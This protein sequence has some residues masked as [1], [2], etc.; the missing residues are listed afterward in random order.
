VVV[1]I[2]ILAIVIGLTIGLGLQLRTSYGSGVDAKLG[3][4]V[5]R[6]FLAD[7]QA[8]AAALSKAD[9]TLLNSRLTEGALA[10][11]VQQIHA[12]SSTSSLPVVSFEAASITIAKAQDP[13]DPTLL[14]KVEEDGVKHVTI[15]GGPDSEPSEKAIAFHGDFWLR[16]VSGRYL[17]ADQSITTLPTS[18][19]PQLA[20]VATGLLWVGLAGL[21]LR[22]TR[23][24]KALPLPEIQL[25]L[26][27]P[28]GSQRPAEVAEEPTP[29][30]IAIRTFG[31]LRVVEGGKDWAAALNARPVMAF[32]WLRMVVAAVRQGAA[33]VMREEIGR[34]TS[35]GL[36]RETQLRRLRNLL[37]Q[38]LRELPDALRSRI[39]VEPQMLKFA[40]TD[41]SVDAIELLELSAQCAGR[42]MLSPAL[43]VRVRRAVDRSGDPFLP[44]FESVEDLATDHHP[45]C[46]DMIRSVREQLLTKRVELTM[47]LADTYA[48]EHKPADAIAV[49]EP[50][51]KAYPERRDIAQRLAAAYRAAGREDEA[52]GL[53]EVIS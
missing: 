15:P 13:N 33:G 18:Y 34:Q 16:L 23:T 36:D 20:L 30:R 37:Y 44:E 25:E 7:Q 24:P 46:G 17:I 19:L 22:R 26:A 8:E 4:Q 28:P 11:V 35:P 51:L 50:A 3:D 6:D 29:A 38:G 1:S 47:V 9:Q 45:T 21:L 42:T 53:A 39:V 32:V 52:R 41:C 49:L 5:Q 14:L 2:L 48:G 10:D 12:Q 40:L 27:P 31:G 43:E